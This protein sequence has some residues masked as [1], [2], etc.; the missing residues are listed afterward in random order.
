MQALQE[1]LCEQL[2]QPKDVYKTVADRKRQEGPQFQPGDY[3]WLSTC[4]L[5]CSGHLWK[6]DAKFIG[7]YLI[8]EGISPVAFQLQLPSVLC[9]HLVFHH[10]HL[11][12]AALPDSNQPPSGAPPPPILVDDEEEYKVSQILDS[13]VH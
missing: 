3:V 11:V 10:I 7:P 2:D 5:G 6:F 12:P 1:L 8:M 13:W 4:Y 9:I